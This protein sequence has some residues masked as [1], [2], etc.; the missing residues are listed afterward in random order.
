[1]LE[2]PSGADEG[3]SALPCVANA[4]ERSV[5][6]LG[7]ARRGEQTVVARQAVRGVVS[8]QFCGVYPLGRDFDGKMLRGVVKRSNKSMCDETTRSME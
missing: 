5:E 7:E 1:M 6:V 4:R 2:A 8:R 3:L